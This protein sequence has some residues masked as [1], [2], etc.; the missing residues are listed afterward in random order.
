MTRVLSVVRW[1]M[2][3]VLAMTS[4]MACVRPASARR[5]LGEP[6][7]RGVDR[8][9]AWPRRDV[10]DLALRAYECG[11][12]SGAFD[13]PLLT[14]IDYSLPSTARRLWVIDVSKR[15]VLFHELVAHGENSGDNVATAFSNVPGSRQSSLGVF[16]T[17]ET[18]RGAHGVSLRLEGL[19]PG[20]ND[21]AM[22][23][24]IVMH[25]APYVD[26]ALAARHG[27]LGRSWG[28]PALSRP[29][30]R[31]VIERIKGGSAL[32]AYYP[33]GRWLRQSRFLRC[34]GVRLASAKLRT[35]PSRGR[36]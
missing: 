2:I 5:A 35:E 17:E 22:E 15:R 26:A 14:V 36:R 7:V 13:T 32:F 19:E 8:V 12:E 33:D 11:T 3:V 28:C 10:L 1:M 30:S 9:G 27:R 4:S 29:V 24:H 16:R 23:R 25:G 6:N 18:Y 34:D 31:R 20:V 21:N